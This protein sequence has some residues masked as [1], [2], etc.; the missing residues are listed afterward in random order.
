MKIDWEKEELAQ[1]MNRKDIYGAAGDNEGEKNKE[2]RK[3]I[4]W[5]D[6]RKWNSIK[7]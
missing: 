2:N 3:N 6:E 7:R 1:P 4:I 5:K